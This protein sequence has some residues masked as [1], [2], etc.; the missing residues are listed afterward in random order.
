MAKLYQTL[1]NRENIDYVEQ[2]G[3]FCCNRNDAWLGSGYYYW[4]SFINWAHIW[5]EQAYGLGNYIICETSLDLNGIAVLN[6]LEPETLLEFQKYIDL[7][8]RIYPQK[9]LTVRFIVEYLKKNIRFPY[10]AI[11]AKGVQRNNSIF[12]DR[13]IQFNLKRGERKSVLDL[14]PQVQICILDKLVIGNHNF[15][16]IFPQEYAAGYAI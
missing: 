4:D 1:E 16:V 8:Q 12:S 13:Y 15:K 3:P 2:N 7:I 10:K 14:R 9:E 6:L 5:G 11:K